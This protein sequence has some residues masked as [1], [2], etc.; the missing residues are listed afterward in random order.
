MNL[1]FIRQPGPHTTIISQSQSII[2]TGFAIHMRRLLWCHHTVEQSWNNECYSLGREKANQRSAATLESTVV[3]PRTAQ[4]CWESPG[5]MSID[6]VLSNVGFRPI[7]CP[8]TAQGRPHH[9]L[10]QIPRES[11][12]A[13]GWRNAGLLAGA[14]LCFLTQVWSGMGEHALRIMTMSRMTL[15][16]SAGV[17]QYSGDLANNYLCWLVWVWCVGTRSIPLTTWRSWPSMT[18]AML[19]GAL[20][21]YEF[22]G[23]ATGQ[24]AIKLTLQREI[25]M[26]FRPFVLFSMF[27]LSYK[28]VHCRTKRSQEAFKKRTTMLQ[29][30]LQ[31]FQGL[32]Q[33]QMYRSFWKVPQGSSNMACPKF[34]LHSKDAG[35][36][37][38]SDSKSTP[39]FV[40]S[41]KLPEIPCKRNTV[42][43]CKI[44]TLHICVGVWVL[45]TLNKLMHKI[46]PN[47]V[48]FAF[49]I[50]CK[51]F[52]C[53]STSTKCLIYVSNA[54][55]CRC[56]EP[57]RCDEAIARIQRLAEAQKIFWAVTRSQVLIVGWSLCCMF[58]YF[59]IIVFHCASLC[60]T[61]LQSFSIIVS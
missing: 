60:F 34:A 4:R 61:M 38:K 51:C 14:I 16:R 5:H 7:H 15:S 9:G 12:W 11:V 43:L 25:F 2:W 31:S 36:L 49:V 44:E 23:I 33:R 45:R 21:W 55:A 56:A 54:S 46:M 1:G 50:C 40:H 20:C 32:C 19:I 47:S 18:F 52:W 53:P 17:A 48:H 24:G 41:D 35:I 13:Q 39:S 37:D 29:Q 30:S 22:S 57:Q 3:H 8:G 26:C 42:K 10:L 6:L 28:V 59:Y 58:H 27:W